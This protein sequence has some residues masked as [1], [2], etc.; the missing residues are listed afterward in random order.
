M[1]PRTQAQARQN[2][3]NVANRTVLHGDNLTFLR[4]INSGTVNLI[5][6][7]PPF[8]KSKDFHATPDSLAAGAKFTDRWK[9]D[10]DVHPDWVDA[11]Q[12]DWPAVWLV[13]KAAEAASGS[14]MAAYLCWLGVRLMEMHRV[15]RD[16]GSI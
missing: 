6:T 3:I 11:I 1:T 7:D 9:W 13:I 14:D 16:D 5:A 8:N 4:G 10:T 15:L 12:D 2:R